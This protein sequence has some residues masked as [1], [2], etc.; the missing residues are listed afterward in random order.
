MGYK[1]VAAP[2]GTRFSK[3]EIQAAVNALDIP[4]EDVM[5]ANIDK[6][7]KRYPNGFETKK[8]LTRLWGDI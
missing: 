1:L 3:G 7:K 4:L 2:D 5:Q 8:S 6:L